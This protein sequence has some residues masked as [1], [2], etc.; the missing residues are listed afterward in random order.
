VVTVNKSDSVASLASRMAY[1]NFQTERFL[2]LNGMTVNSTLSA[3]QKV[4]IVT[5]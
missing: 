1:K 4:K 2:A 3:G 5:Y